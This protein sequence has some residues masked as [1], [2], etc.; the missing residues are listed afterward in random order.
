MA[1]V[2]K[3]NVWMR[4]FWKDKSDL[5]DTEEWPCINK[6]EASWLNETAVVAAVH[7]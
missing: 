6:Q 3:E 7:I 5:T 4:E 2:L 1:Q